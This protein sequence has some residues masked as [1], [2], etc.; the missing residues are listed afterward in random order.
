[1]L[2]QLALTSPYKLDPK[3]MFGVFFYLGE[4]MGRPTKRNPALIEAILIGLEEGRYENGLCEELGVDPS[5]VRSW[6]RG[7][8]E[9][10]EQ[11]R[12]ARCDGILARLE[13][14]KLKLETAVGRDEILRAKECLAHSRWEAEKLLK[15]FQPVQKQEVAHVGPYVIG[16]DVE[17]QGEEAARIVS[18]E[19][20]DSITSEDVSN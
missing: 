6:K 15:D 18:D 17:P 1:M 20:L 13:L 4:P 16:W 9:L 10:R 11:V 14:D 3:H 7:D 8:G 5:A 12:E 2:S 19:Y